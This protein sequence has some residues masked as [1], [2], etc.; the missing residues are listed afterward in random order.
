[1]AGLEMVQTYWKCKKHFD[2]FYNNEIKFELV[3][4]FTVQ[5]VLEERCEDCNY[6]DHDGEDCDGHRYCEICGSG[7][8]TEGW[9]FEEDASYRCPLTACE[10]KDLW[11]GREFCKTPQEAYD[12]SKRQGGSICY[13]TEWE[14]VEFCRCPPTCKCRHLALQKYPIYFDATMIHKVEVLGRGKYGALAVINSQQG[15][16][17]HDDLIHS[18]WGSTST[19]QEPHRMMLEEEVLLD[20]NLGRVTLIEM[21]A[22]SAKRLINEGS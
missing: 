7:P 19:T 21:P 8:L 18:I 9:C 22:D 1:M 20:P 15:R 10:P 14:E 13:Y 17:S 11:I 16:L 2:Q 6:C 12:A 3:T 5:L 4:T